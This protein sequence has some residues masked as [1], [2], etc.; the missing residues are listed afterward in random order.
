MQ[1]LRRFLVSVSAVLLVQNS[2]FAQSKSVRTTVRTATVTVATA[3]LRI[4]PTESSRTL[5]L[6]DHAAK[7][8]VLARK[9]GWIQIQTKRGTKGWIRRDLVDIHKAV[10]VTTEPVKRVAST[11]NKRK[12]TVVKSKVVRIP[13]K[14]TPTKA[15]TV[16]PKTDVSE[17]VSKT[18]DGQLPEL[19]K[20]A[21]EQTAN[22]VDIN[23]PIS[24]KRSSVVDFA[25]GAANA[26]KTSSPTRSTLMSRA[27]S[28]RGT[29]Y[30]YGTSG[31]GTYDCSGFTSAMY[32]KVGVKLPRTAAEQ[33][34]VGLHIAKPSLTKGDLVFFR[35]TAG[36]RGI[37]HV[38]IYS[39][40]GMFIH[41]S[42]RG[43]AVRVDTLSSGYYANHFAGGRRLI[44]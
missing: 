44:R 9:S 11:V 27:N 7:V 38:G 30:R 25:Q 15:V 5:G 29:P 24:E 12:P 1:F 37:S 33:F 21:S 32:R 26:N 2:G 40:N 10:V 36:R 16:V 35:N 41:A 14:V 28:Q 22:R 31:G 23:D 17:Q 39:G 4:K 3:K 6:L 20:A 13:S 43:H 18:S 42:S 8:S 19:V 34:S